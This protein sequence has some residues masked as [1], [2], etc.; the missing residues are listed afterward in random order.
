MLCIFVFHDFKKTCRKRISKIV[1][2]D[3]SLPSIPIHLTSNKLTIPILRCVWMLPDLPLYISGDRK[4]YK[5]LP[6]S[7]WALNLQQPYPLEWHLRLNWKIPLWWRI[8][9]EIS[10][11]P[12]IGYCWTSFSFQVRTSYLCA[13]TEWSNRHLSLPLNVVTFSKNN[14]S[15]S[16]PRREK[17]S[18]LR[19]SRSFKFPS[20]MV[21]GKFNE[22]LV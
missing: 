13:E 9:R 6:K 10:E 5:S 1:L 18:W 11:I 20:R 3:W 19:S 4:E 15:V 21:I 7:L 12:L 8:S 22:S 16:P 14:L 17:M 2:Q